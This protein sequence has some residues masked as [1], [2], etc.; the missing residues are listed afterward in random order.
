M[1]ARLKSVEHVHLLRVHGSKDDV[2]NYPASV[3]ELEFRS[4]IKRFEEQFTQLYL[5][6]FD[7]LEYLH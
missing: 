3:K 2:E 6:I 1:P 5:T 4:E 7:L